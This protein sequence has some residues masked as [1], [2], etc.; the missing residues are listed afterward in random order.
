MKDFVASNSIA[1]YTLVKRWKA[2][3]DKHEAWRLPQAEGETMQTTFLKKGKSPVG[4]ENEH[5]GS[6]CYKKPK[7]KQASY[8]SRPYKTPTHVLPSPTWLPACDT[9]FYNLNNTL[10]LVI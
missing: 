1:F 7:P 8:N 5:A 10:T 4:P 3:T 2:N 6:L 9:H